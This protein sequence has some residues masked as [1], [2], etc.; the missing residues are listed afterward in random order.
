M[1][2]NKSNER[3]IV[4]KKL[5][6]KEPMIRLSKPKLKIIGGFVI[7]VEKVSDSFMIYQAKALKEYKEKSSFFNTSKTLL[8]KLLRMYRK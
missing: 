1:V 2:I 4:R 6:C 3:E 7:S 8:H 5:L